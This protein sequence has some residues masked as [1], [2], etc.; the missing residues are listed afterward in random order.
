MPIVAHSPEFKSTN[1]AMAYG[2]FSAFSMLYGLQPLMP[3]LSADFHVSAVAGS[4]VISVS[5]ATLAASLIPAS[6]VARRYGLKPIMCLALALSAFLTLIA[7][8][9]T[10]LT[11]L[12][13]CRGLLGIA[14]AGFPAIAMAYLGEEIDA[15]ALGRSIGIYIAGS[16]LGGLCGR[17]LMAFLADWLSWRAALC[18][19]GC[20]GL[21]VAFEFWRLLPNSQHFEAQRFKLKTWWADVTSHWSDAGL[22]WLF[23]QG[24]L[25]MGCYVSLYNYLGYRLV[26]A[27]FNFRPASLGMMSAMNVIG[28]FASTW[29]GRAADQYGRRKVLWWMVAIMMAGL[30]VTLTNHISLLLIGVGIFTFGFFSAHAMAS[31]WVGRRAQTAKTL[32]SSFYVSAYYL[33]SSLVGTLSGFIW[34]SYHWKGMVIFLGILLSVCMFIALEL[35]KLVPLK[36][37]A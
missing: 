11:Q 15:L 6:I 20:V 28:I 19:L 10:N 4:G 32:A 25:L 37:L 22:P 36:V 17:M 35:R 33:G 3:M 14:L 13:V 18:S 23:M 7:A 26:A 12:L 30:M 1:R 9:T 24:F 16:A 5:A 31:S 34:Q 8:C 21:I 29:A 27:P 2:G